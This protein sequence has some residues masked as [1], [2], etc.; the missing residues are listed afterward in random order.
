[1]AVTKTLV[2]EGGTWHAI[3]AAWVCSWRGWVV[4]APREHAAE[5]V[6]RFAASWERA[7]I[8]QV[9]SRHLKH[10]SDYLDFHRE[11]AKLVGAI[12][13]HRAVRKVIRAAASETLGIPDA[14]KR[15]R[16]AI[17]KRLR[18]D[19]RKA[20]ILFWVA[21]NLA[22]TGP[23]AVLP[24][25]NIALSLALLCAPVSTSQVPARGAM[26][27]AGVLD[28]LAALCIK[29]ISRIY[30]L[31]GKRARGAPTQQA[32]QGCP[33]LNTDAEVLIFAHHGFGYGGLYESSYYFRPELGSPLN[34]NNLLIVEYLS[35]PQG[36]NGHLE[37]GGTL[38]ADQMI[39][40]AMRC[41]RRAFREWIRLVG[42][43]ALPPTIA[44]VSLIEGYRNAL[45]GLHRARLAIIHFDIQC[46]PELIIAA[47][48]L[49]ITC[50][51]LQARSN[52]INVPTH[53]LM[54]DH[55]FTFGPH[56][57][58]AINANP[59]S[60]IG[61][62]HA[63]GPIRADWIEARTANEHPMPSKKTILVL[64]AHSQANDASP[65]VPKGNSWENNG[66]FLDRVI[67]L[68]EHFEDCRFVIRGKDTGWMEIPYFKNYLERI[69]DRPNLEID[70]D[71]TRLGRSYDMVNAA[72]LIFARH[73]SLGDEALAKGVPV[74]F[75]EETVNGGKIVS[76]FTDYAGLPIFAHTFEGALCMIAAAL[77]NG[78][79]ISGDRMAELRKALF[80]EPRN[81]EVADRFHK[82]LSDILS[83]R[84]SSVS[85]IATA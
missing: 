38:A 85:T 50:V 73:T 79:S 55:Y 42:L 6:N 35:V 54:F 59:Y 48:S 20:S 52:A 21:N 12:V 1:M 14:E 68:S 63:V 83:A 45:S 78:R 70:Q 84:H 7:G 27:L 23:V 3:L 47:Q 22:Q 53:P 67:R 16:H 62:C 57:D 19:L 13:D 32:T 60:V 36:S 80:S 39:P 65:D 46:P 66:L 77:N 30:T 75:Y 11:L 82:V 26:I 64:D 33:P 25:P 5:P 28:G 37:V 9:T 56:F 41:I 8:H 74:I 34:K 4:L 24:R 43:L 44:T 15:L 71:Y 51:A 29:S 17:F 40:L 76:G 72:D 61:Q 49:G 31:F 81:Y 69:A 18:G 10:G 58:D 2:T